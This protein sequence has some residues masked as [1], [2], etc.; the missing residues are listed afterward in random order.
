MCSSDLAANLQGA[1][2]STGTVQSQRGELFGTTGGS[3]PNVSSS[4]ENVPVD[5]RVEQ[6][7][8][9]D[10]LAGNGLQIDNPSNPG[11]APQ[12][13]DIPPAHSNRGHSSKNSDSEPDASYFGAGAIGAFGANGHNSLVTALTEG[14][15]ARQDGILGGDDS[16]LELLSTIS[17]QIGR[18]HV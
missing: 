11:E 2:A 6:K 16:K 3:E 8:Y 18:A 4:A 14:S 13:K 7:G 12:A 1:T 5:G 9:S 10:P 17:D 15:Q